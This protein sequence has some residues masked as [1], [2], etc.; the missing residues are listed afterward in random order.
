MKVQDF[1][2][3]V[4]RALQQRELLAG[5]PHM[6]MLIL[7]VIGIATV[8]MAQLYWFL[9]VL[10]FLYI[11]MRILSKKDPYLIDVILISLSQDDSY[12]P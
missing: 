7:L 1:A 12:I 8:Y 3:P 6:A 9:P 4:H 2:I 11:A 10:I 5:I